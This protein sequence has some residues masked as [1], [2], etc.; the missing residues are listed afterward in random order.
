M[1]SSIKYLCS[2]LLLS[3]LFIST[4]SYAAVIATLS[5][6][7]SILELDV[8]LQ[9]P[10]GFGDPGPTTFAG[11]YNYES[12][13]SLAT[14]TIE[15]II[16]NTI[17]YEFDDLSVNSSLTLRYA[18]NDTVEYSYNDV[19]VQ[20]EDNV[21]VLSAGVANLVPDGTYDVFTVGAYSEGASFDIFGNLSTGLEFNLT[22]YTNT[23]YFNGLMDI[24]ILLQCLVDDIAILNVTESQNGAPIR[25]A[26]GEVDLDT[27]TLH[28]VVPVPAGIWMML[29]GVFSLGWFRFNKK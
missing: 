8:G 18:N 28:T 29:S 3:I 11:V 12:N 17:R 5:G 20:L 15:N 23:D 21:N 13:S 1:K 22:Y 9:L 26:I 7:G 19:Y 2:T 6:E 16:P 27:L 10:F 25:L 4:Q 24:P 14:S